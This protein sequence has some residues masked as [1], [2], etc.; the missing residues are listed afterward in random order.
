MSDEVKRLIEEVTKGYT[1]K[2]TDVRDMQEL[3]ESPLNTLSLDMIKRLIRNGRDRARRLQKPPKLATISGGAVALSGKK[4]HHTET[5][6]SL[7]AT[8]SA[9]R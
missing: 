2:F 7:Q 4:R 6:F 3:R 1:L 8:T 9:K 5:S